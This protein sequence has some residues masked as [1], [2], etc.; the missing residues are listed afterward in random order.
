LLKLIIILT[1]TIT[2]VSVFADHPV[3]K[4]TSGICHAPDSSHYNRTSKYQA[5]ENL[6][7]CLKSGGR[8]PKG[9]SPKN[10]STTSS[11][12][13]SRSKFGSGWG[14]LNSDCQDSRQEALIAQSTAPVRFHDSKECRVASGR[15][16][17][18][19][20]GKTIHDPSAIDIDHVVPL[21][22]AWEHGASD[23]SKPKRIKLANDPVNL[24]SVEAS[25]NRQKGAKGP[26]EWLPPAN[27]CQYLARFYRVVLKYRLKLSP[28]EEAF[29]E[30]SLRQCQ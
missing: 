12:D 8:L 20:S 23:W 4:S 9:Y 27:H 28:D 1:L 26:D 16:L 2:S 24:L 5:F 22:W 18:P 7:V 15:W 29:K 13:Y 6:E 17:S 11:T 21:K 25:L 14:D 19:Y 10:G 3:K 30:L